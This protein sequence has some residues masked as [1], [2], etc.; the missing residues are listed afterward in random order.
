MRKAS[1]LILSSAM[2]LSCA[3]LVALDQWTKALAAARL[4]GRGTLRLVGDFAVLVFVSNRGA[5][6][7]LGSGLPPVLRALLLLVL[8]LVA[9]AFFAW[10]FLRR[11]PGA[12]SKSGAGSRGGASARRGAAEYAALALI[13]AG[14]IGNLIDRLLFGEVRDFLN[15][16]LGSLRT[17]IMNLADL[18]ILAAIIVIVAGTAARSGKARGTR[19][20][21]DP[22]A[23]R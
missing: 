4:A 9:L 14:G 5:F 6:L 12:D 8:P 17:G 23:P 18:Y 22:D 2:I 21:A 16:G 10:I 20:P 15:F 19:E 11:A 3:G 13:A 7:S 1:R